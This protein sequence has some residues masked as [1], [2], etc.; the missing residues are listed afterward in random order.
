MDSLVGKRILIL[1]L[2][3]QGEA[4]ARFAA[5]VGAEVVVSDLRP[6]EALRQP[7][8]DLNGLDITYVL[9]EHP[10]TLLD[11]TDVVAVSGGVPVSAP[12]VAAAR[13][14]GIRITNDSL[15]FVSRSPA[16]VVGI[17]GSAGKTTTTSLCGE[18]ARQSGR[19]T[20]V[21]GNIGRPLLGDLAQMRASDLV[22]QE[23]SSFQLEIWSSDFGNEEINGPSV[24]AVLN[25]TPNHL[26][27]HKTMQAYADAKAN[28]LRQ[29]DDDSVAVL[30]ADDEGAMALK[31]HVRG[32]LRTYSAQGAVEDGA[33]VQAG[34][35]WLRGDGNDIE[36]CQLGE[37][38]L[39]GEHNVLNVLAAVTLADCAG[40][41]AQSMR[42]AITTFKGVPHRLEV[43]ARIGDVTYVNDSIATAPERSLAGIAAF[44]EPLVLLAG[45]RDKEMAWERWARRVSQRAR[46]VVLFGE[47]AP[48][49]DELLARQQG[50]VA[51]VTRRDSFDEAVAYASDVARPGDVVL[52]SP[53]GTSYDAFADFEERGERF[54]QRVQ[55][56]AREQSLRER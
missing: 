28:L 16:P 27:R 48:Q 6:A 52:L 7:L 30:C 22:V 29:Q 43:V 4:L 45:G 5:A 39:R 54:R 36:L 11:G 24:A 2:A 50:R 14:R 56:L 18:I 47:L 25:V 15:E 44:D 55:A 3:R 42:R 49:L 12:I 23:L 13:R 21:G 33:F 20:W 8:Q 46:H 1:G 10:M 40:I 17:T 26:D 19:K 31:R 51:M 9:G 34:Q 41:D 37:I 38:S 32:R 53:G 35:V